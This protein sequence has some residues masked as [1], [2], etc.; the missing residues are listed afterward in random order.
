MAEPPRSNAIGLGLLGLAVLF[1]AAV[2]TDFRGL[3]TRLFTDSTPAKAVPALAKPALE[4]PAAERPAPAA[5]LA[6]SVTPAWFLDASGFDGGELE[7][8]SARA[9]MVVYFQKKACEACRRFEREVLAAPEV[10][11]FLGGVVKVRVGVDAGD[12]EQKL[13]RRFGVEDL[14]A[15]VAV[16]QR[17]APHVVPVRRA[18]AFLSPQELVS[19]LR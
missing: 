15:L 7:R 19:F 11:S 12:R 10:K 2:A 13:A 4:K 17:G 6:A 8:Q 3:Q 1:A 18:K 16:P 5:A 9:P 14:P